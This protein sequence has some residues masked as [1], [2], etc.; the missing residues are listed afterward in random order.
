M[1]K[2]TTALSISLDGFIAG[3][4]DSSDLPLGEGGDTLFRWA[5]DGDTPSRQ[6]PRAS[7][8]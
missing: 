7:P 2:V 8:T 6:R 1:T 4:N 5:T 3:A